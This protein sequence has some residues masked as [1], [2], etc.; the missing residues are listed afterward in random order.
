MLWGERGPGAGGGGGVGVAPSRGGPGG[1]HVAALIPVIVT[2][3]ASGGGHTQRTEVCVGV[4][5]APPGGVSSSELLE[6]EEKGGGEGGEPVGEGL[7]GL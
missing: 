1:T 2:A 6:L 7:G 3:A 4:P 5:C